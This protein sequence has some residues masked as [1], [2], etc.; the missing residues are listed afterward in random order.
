[1]DPTEKAQETF[2]SDLQ[3]RLKGTVWTTGC[4]SWYMN[5]RGDIQVLWPQTV[6]KFI[7]MFKNT[8]FESDFI[9]V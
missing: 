9:K 5:K 2:S 4:K 7:N 3:E 8:D 6:T 1:M